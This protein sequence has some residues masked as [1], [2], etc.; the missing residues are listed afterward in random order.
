[1]AL[2]DVVQVTILNAATAPQQADFGTPLILGKTPW[3]DLVRTY[4]SGAAMLADGFLVTDAVYQA[5]LKLLAQ[6]PVLPSFKVGKRNLLP[7]PT[8]RI[9][10]LVASA[11]AVYSVNVA[12][13]GGVL[14][15][16]T[17]TAGASPTIANVTAGL[18][19]AIDALAVPGLVTTDAGTWLTA[20]CA[21]GLWF[22]LGLAPNMVTTGLLALADVTADAGIA[23]DLANILGFDS[24]WYGFGS[25]WSSTAEATA[26]AVW[27]EANQ[28]QQFVT[29]MDTNV[30]TSTTSNLGA[31]L[32]ALGYKYTAVLYSAN[33]GD[34]AGI[35][36]MGNRYPFP[37]GG[38][39]WM[40]AQ[41]VGV[42]PSSLT[43]T[44]RANLTANNVNFFVT[45]AGINVVF[46]GV[47]SGGQYIDITRGNDWLANDMAVGIYGAL[48]NAGGKVPY[49]DAGVAIVE[50]QVR[51][52]LRRA[53]DRNFM[54]SNPAPTILVPPVSAQA[55]ADK[56]GRILRNLTFAGTYAGALD[57]VIIQGQITF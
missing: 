9:T 55:P 22:N 38:E 2:S 31:T 44:Q 26:A 36:W 49:T 19:A 10:P 23:T 27:A 5:A 29:T 51:G 18:K 28:K 50:A 1:M 6:N 11:N 45:T 37:A 15:T 16:A 39:N 46:L 24:G 41:L 13:A 7:V 3:V 30:A 12:A 52:S 32:K 53:Q 40:F 8:M 33:Q 42:T 57:K 48:A 54:S 25:V 56:A 43:P 20:S 21:A 4:N 14:T 47:A 17:Y 35:A 34:F